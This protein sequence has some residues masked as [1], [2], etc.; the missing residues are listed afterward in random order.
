MSR[1]ARTALWLATFVAV[2]F[3]AIITKLWLLA[4]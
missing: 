2:S 4:N 3:F 1:N